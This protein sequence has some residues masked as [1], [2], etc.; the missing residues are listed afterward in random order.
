MAKSSATAKDEFIMIP[1]CCINF[2][3]EKN[4][5]KSEFLEASPT[6]NKQQD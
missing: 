1:A 5:Q 4:M 6:L 2:R 3:M